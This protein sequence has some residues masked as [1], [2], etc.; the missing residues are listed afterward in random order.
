MSKVLIA[1]ISSLRKET[2]LGL[3]KVKDALVE[4]S[5]DYEAAKALL[6]KRSK[7]FIQIGDTNEGTVEFY[8]HHN[9]QI[10]AM[11]E[12]NCITD[13][14]ARNEDFKKLAMDVA[15]HV[16]GANPS[17]ISPEDI[18]PGLIEDETNR[19]LANVSGKPENIIGRILEGA[20][21]KFY[22]RHCLL[23]QP[24][25]KDESKTVGEMLSELSAKTGENITVKRFARFIVGK[26]K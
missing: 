16:A 12:L 17:S 11:V 14:N 10:G 20:M 18:P 24:F 3:S 22:S 8:R 7:E 25:V 21:K 2:G 1:Q 19:V 23:H 13:F 15:I 26:E 4:T 6:K 5:G 9:G